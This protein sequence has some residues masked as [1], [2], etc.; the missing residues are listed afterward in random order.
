MIQSD[1]LPFLLGASLT[2]FVWIIVFAI[3][4]AKKQELFGVDS[5]T[6]TP[7][8]PTGE[9]ILTSGLERR[10]ISASDLDRMLTGPNCTDSGLPL[11]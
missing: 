7:I 9:M 10:V 3:R 8:Y 2:N 6:A 1:L 11:R 4:Y 5:W